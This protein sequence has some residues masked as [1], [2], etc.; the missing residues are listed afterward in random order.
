M[1][2]VRLLCC[3]DS[4][5]C[6]KFSY[7]NVNSFPVPCYCTIFICFFIGDGMKIITIFNVRHI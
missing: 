2:G 4:K 1:G 7:E 6:T 5:D 3:F